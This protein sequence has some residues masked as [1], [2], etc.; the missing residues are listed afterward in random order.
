MKIHKVLFFFIVLILTIGN[1]QKKYNSHTYDRRCKD[2]LIVNGRLENSWYVNLPLREISRYYF[3]PIWEA[4][5]RTIYLLKK[6]KSV[7]QQIAF[8][9]YNEEN[10][11][12]SFEF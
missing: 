9:I 3:L 8:H 2:L 11:N 4:Q 10:T 12:C 5:L 7:Y 6:K 1:H